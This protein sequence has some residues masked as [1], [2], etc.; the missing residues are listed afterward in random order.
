MKHGKTI[1][2]ISIINKRELLKIPCYDC[3]RRDY[4]P[5]KDSCC[6][7][8]GHIFKN[9]S[10]EKA[11]LT[12]R[13]N[14]TTPDYIKELNK[15]NEE[16]AKRQARDNDPAYNCLAGTRRDMPCPNWAAERR[17]DMAIIRI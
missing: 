2:D 15:I 13:K 4:I 1:G 3:G 11:S 8:C 9:I 7:N 6:P 5:G 14:N 16:T 17:K 12:G 10:G